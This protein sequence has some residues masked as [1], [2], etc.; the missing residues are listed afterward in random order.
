MGWLDSKRALVAGAGS[1][2]GRAV[3]EAFHEE[4]AEDALD[5]RGG[6]LPEV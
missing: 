4:G 3:L 1:G 6:T 2:I 5:C